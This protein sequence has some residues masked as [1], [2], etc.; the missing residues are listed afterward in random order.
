M[1]ADVGVSMMKGKM[2][3]RAQLL[4]W[5]VTVWR[6]E[7]AALHAG[8]GLDIAC[9]SC[10]HSLEARGEPSALACDGDVVQCSTCLL[11][12]HAKCHAQMGE[13]IK[14]S[15]GSARGE[16]VRVMALFTCCLCGQ[17]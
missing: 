1:I 3:F 15:F 14:V 10:L 11:G 7:E 2:A 6:A 5:V 16:D 12:F 9:S 17:K 4:G 13:L 8:H